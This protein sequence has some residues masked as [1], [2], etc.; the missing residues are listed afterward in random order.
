M[1]ARV[2]T[3][4]D[5]DDNASSDRYH[6]DTSVVTPSSDSRA[7]TN[8]RPPSGPDDSQPPNGP[9]RPPDPSPSGG[10]S[11]SGS[12]TTSAEDEFKK[13]LGSLYDPSILGDYVRNASYGA[14]NNPDPA[15]QDLINRIVNRNLLRGSNESGSSYVSNGTGGYTVGPTGRVNDPRAATSRPPAPPGG[16]NNSNGSGDNGANSYAAQGVNYPGFQFNDPYTNL[17]EQ[18]AKNQ[19]E[20]LTGQNKQMTQLMDFLNHQFTD[21][22]TSQGYTPDEFALLNTQAL[23][24][25]E[26][27]RKASQ[28][29]ELQ[30]TSAAGYLPTSG[31]TLD[32]QRQ[33]DTDYDKARTAASRDLAI[34]GINRQDQQRQQA[35]NVGMQALQLPQQQNQQALDVAG[36]LYN[37]PRQAMMDAN[38]IVNGSSPQS[39]ISPYIQLMQQQQQAA[40]FAQQQ[41][42]AWLQNI[43]AWLYRMFQNNG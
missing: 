5:Y 8:A 12:G 24:P 10:G 17:L 26:A 14:G 15:N 34:N 35:V 37:I 29:R 3:F 38:T 19:I 33:I 40:Q 7:T 27:M 39:V 23:E 41:N 9:P 25:I 20:S 13:R 43:G 31:I 30:R 4:D 18:I 32:Q 6:A 28:Q 1:V 16:N 11:G 42:D 21:L 22:S 36:L 2:T